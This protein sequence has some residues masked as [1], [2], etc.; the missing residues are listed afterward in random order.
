MLPRPQATSVARTT[1]GESLARH[2]Q[3]TEFGPVCRQTA[4]WEK[5]PQSED[6]LTVNVWAPVNKASKPYPVLFFIYGGG[7][8]SGSGSDWGPEGGKSI[9]QNGMIFVTMNYRL[10]V[11]GFFAHPELSAEASDHASGNQALRDQFAALQWT[12]TS[13]RLAA[14]RIVSPLPV[15]RLAESR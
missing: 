4:D 11:L 1:A 9:V 6:C 14:I 5:A 8:D 13:P 12:T 3:A 7:F 10:G 15:T 2:S